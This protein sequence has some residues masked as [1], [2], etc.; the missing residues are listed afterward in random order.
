MTVKAVGS[1]I[2]NVKGKGPVLPVQVKET[3]VV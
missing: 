3:L 1:L 2:G